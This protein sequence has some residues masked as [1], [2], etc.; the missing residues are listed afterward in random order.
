MVKSIIQRELISFLFGSLNR[1]VQN[2]RFVQLIIVHVNI[3]KEN[4]LIR[5]FLFLFLFFSL[6]QEK[7]YL[8]RNSKGIILLIVILEYK[9][10]IFKITY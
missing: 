4:P 10:K 8:E 6:L 1:F 2:I 7:R 9:K 5:I 3:R